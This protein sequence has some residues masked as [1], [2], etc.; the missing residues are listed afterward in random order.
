VTETKIPIENIYYLLCYAWKQLDEAGRVNVNVSDY[1]QYIDLFARV[2]NNGCNYLFKRGLDREYCIEKES[3][4]GIK[5]KIDFSQSL[6]I[7]MRNSPKMYCEYDELSY[8]ILHN[9]IIKAVIRKVLNVTSLDKNIRSDLMDIYCKMHYISDLAINRNHFKKV[10]IHR[11][12][13]FYRFVLN[14]AYMISENIVLDES[15]GNYE[16]VD[17]VR[18][19]KKMTGV[20]ESFVR[21]FYKE[22][23]NSKGYVVKPEIL[24]WDAQSDDLSLDF[25]PEMKTDISITS[26]SRKII[27]DTK[28]YKECFQEFYD[29]KTIISRHLYQL[30]AY[31]ENHDLQEKSGT[32]SEGILLYPT[33]RYEVSLPYT[34]QGHR[35]NIHTINLDQPWKGISE[36]LLGF[37]C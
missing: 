11:N 2:L 13:L 34:I 1:N 32:K 31:L 10:R 5:G 9:Q 14:I 16:F 22:H 12:N 30:M 24:K 29:K 15:S 8:D 37:I 28:Y 19:E 23:L 4:S 20:F 6:N 25:L 36:D 27:I 17:F 3:I 35:I 21:N 7:I 18:D 26:P 33:V